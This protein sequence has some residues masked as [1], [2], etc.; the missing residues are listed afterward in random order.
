VNST[1]TRTKPN[2]RMEEILARAAELFY[3]KGYHAT[4]IE[5]VAREVGML[6]GSLYYHIRSKEDLLYELLLGIIVKGVAHASKAIEGVEDP[7]ER[8]KKAVEAQIE[9]IIQ[10]QT[11][12]GLFLHEFDTLSGRRQK[13]IQEEML[14]YQ[15]IF[16]DAIREGQKQGH[17]VDA[18]TLLLTDAIL[19]M[20][21]WI[22][23]WYPGTKNTG[24][25]TIK[26]TFITFI[27][28]GIIRR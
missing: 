1:V 3:K 12:V 26:K 10:N 17:F 5:D 18:D 16:V 13:R 8:L 14:K 7:T 15:K 19:G 25:D 9:H 20:T 11:Y 6:K 24:P 21:N 2:A 22:Y 28:N 27:M 23:R 4:T